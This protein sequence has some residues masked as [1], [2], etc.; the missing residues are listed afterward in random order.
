M[1]LDQKLL[2]IDE[3]L[4][5][6]HENNPILDQ[7]L[8]II[9]EQLRIIHENTPILDQKLPIIDEQ[10]PIID[11]KLRITPALSPSC[12]WFQRSLRSASSASLPEASGEPA[13]GEAP[14][15]AFWG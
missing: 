3:Q 13:T 10:L 14:S 4:R 8:P 2:I 7:K 1:S 15:G 12:D 9:D 5:I 11:Q 6:I